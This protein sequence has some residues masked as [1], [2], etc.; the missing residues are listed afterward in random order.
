MIIV[1]NNH[2]QLFQVILLKIRFQ[3]SSITFL[4]LLDLLLSD[5]LG[6][7]SGIK[8]LIRSIIFMDHRTIRSA[9]IPFSSSLQNFSILYLAF[10]LLDIRYFGFTD[11]TIHQQ[12]LQPYKSP[13]ILFNLVFIHVRNY[14]FLIIFINLVQLDIMFI[15]YLSI[16][17]DLY[18]I[19]DDFIFYK[20]HFLP[21]LLLLVLLEIQIVLLSIHTSLQLFFQHL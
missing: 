3:Q 17:V 16:G 13:Y 20:I 4:L 10:H 9:S 15:Q 18:I 8:S 7:T 6:I 21:F 11:F 14:Y 5:Y 2:F 1:N 19:I 12:L